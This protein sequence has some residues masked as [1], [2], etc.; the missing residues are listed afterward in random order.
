MHV[1]LLPSSFTWRRLISKRVRQ[2]G[3]VFGLLTIAILGWNAN[4][5]AKWLKKN[6]ELQEIF[7]VAEPIREMQSDRI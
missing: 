7:A 6:L 1:N 5:F 2:W 3:W 4:L